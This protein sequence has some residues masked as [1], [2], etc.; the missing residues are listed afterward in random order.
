MF[1]KCEAD[2][3]NCMKN[4]GVDLKLESMLWAGKKNRSKVHEMDVRTVIAMLQVG[5]ALRSSL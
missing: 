3:I 2:Y 4:I 5:D 1:Y